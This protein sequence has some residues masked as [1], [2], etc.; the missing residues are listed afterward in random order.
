MRTH[1]FRLTPGTDLR[2]GIEAAAA[3]FGAAA[4]VVLTCVGSLERAALRMAGRSDVET[5]VGDLE[6]VSLVGTL[7]PDGAHLHLAVADAS[8]RMTGGHLEPGCIVRTTAEVVL[9]G[10]EG[11]RFRRPVDPA[12]TWDELV[13]ER[14]DV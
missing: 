8:G 7:S 14:V 1:A 5:L 6:I 2:A 4:I 10:L 13:V 11:V 9:G 3:E 12:T